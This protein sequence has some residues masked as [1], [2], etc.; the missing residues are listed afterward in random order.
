MTRL[1][2][3]GHSIELLNL[4]E[5][6]EYIKNSNVTADDIIDYFTPFTKP[7]ATEKF[8]FTRQWMQQEAARVGDFR[9]KDFRTVRSFNFPPE[10]VLINR[11][12]AGT[13]SI[14]CQLNAEIAFRSIVEKWQP[15][16][17]TQQ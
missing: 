11:I 2:L 8:H 4:L 7:L 1:A 9:G 6:M 15:R 16:S 5:E 17:T 3:H 14:L 12:C 10:F 13:T